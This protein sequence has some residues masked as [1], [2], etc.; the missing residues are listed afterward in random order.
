MT[1]T[2]LSL[3]LVTDRASAIL[4]EVE[5]AVV[6]KRHSLEL[7]LCGV[8]AGGHVLMEDFPGLGKTLAARSFA[9]ALGLDFARAQFTPDLL[10][11]DLTGSFLY[12]QR[13]HEFTFRK[14]PLFTGLLLADEINRTPPKTQ[15]ALLEAMQEGQATVEG[16]TFVL[17]KPFHVLATANPVEYEGT[18]PLPEAQL[19]RFL[20]RV[21]F[22]YPTAQEEWEVLERRMDR[23]QEAQ[24]VD[25][26]TDAAGLLEMQRAVET[27]TV[28]QSVGQYCVRLVAETRRHQ[29][30][31]MGASP[32][33]S[34][35]L[36][37]TARA[38]AVVHGRD[39]VTPEDV[40]AVAHA[41]L[42]HR[43]TVRPEL[44]MNDVSAAS[45]VDSILTSVA[46]PGAVDTGRT[47]F[48][49]P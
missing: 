44:W 29:S 8:L 31:L 47:G 10:P 24:E 22:G 7:V 26:V 41:A 6:G 35:A 16:E 15:S 48:E 4:G 46:A 11:S 42:D 32:R 40:K 9:Q 19:D 3:D 21:S 12:D 33:G 43:V 38:Y 2:N 36:L 20:L 5:R 27:V 28:D 14:G 13:N 39:Y 30:L 37:L 23:G 45:V 17:P 49:R 1:Q 25:R 18:Y 34:L